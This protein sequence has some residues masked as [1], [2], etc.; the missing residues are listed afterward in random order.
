MASARE[1]RADAARNR[2][3][4]LGAILAAT[5][6]AACS[7]SGSPSAAD[8]S[9]PSV[10][11]GITVP[12]IYVPPAGTVVPGPTSCPAEFAAILRSAADGVEYRLA[13]QRD[14]HLLSCRYQAAPGAHRPGGA[15]SG[16][17]IM[18]NTEPQAFAAFDRW[19]VETG[20]NSM[21]SNNPKLRPTPISGVG[22]LAEWVPALLEL[23]TANDTTW[24]S[25]TLACPANTP[26]VLALAK[27]LATAGLA[28][29]A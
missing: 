11:D 5:L 25:V 2:R 4:L 1:T 10:V 13:S 12:P 6:V 29:T 20:Q 16:A 22:T 14:S 9:G 15:C 24:V 26:P 27:Q 3:R 8:S 7:S 28:T 21:W 19:N 23:G 17:T 18:V